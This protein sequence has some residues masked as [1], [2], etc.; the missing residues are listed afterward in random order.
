[1]KIGIIGG[2]GFIG[3]KIVEQLSNEHSFFVVKPE[4]YGS[5]MDLVSFK[6]D[7]VINACAS[8]PSASKNDSQV[9]NFDYPLGVFNLISDNFSHS[10]TWIQLAS[11]YELESEKGGVNWYTRHKIEL[12]SSLQSLCAVKAN[13]LRTLF[14]PHVIGDGERP[15]RL[16]SSA[17]KS[18]KNNIEFELKHPEV[19]LP[20]LVIEDAVCAV[21]QFLKNEQLIAS[22]TPIWYKSNKELLQEISELLGKS[23]EE[24]K[25]LDKQQTEFAGLDFPPK[26]ED[27]EPRITL[28]EYV[29]SFEY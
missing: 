14:L 25:P 5:S 4:I 28:K 3:S 20:I 18:I 26:V 21:K 17:I 11:Y 29:L 24:I 10:F 23:I 27:W 6:P 15:N 9:A 16:V 12:R 2:R 19:K 22:A 1:M 13:N 7:L 8:L